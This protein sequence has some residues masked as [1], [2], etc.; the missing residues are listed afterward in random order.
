MHVLCIPYAVDDLERQR[1]SVDESFL[2]SMS[3]VFTKTPNTG[4]A[5]G[6]AHTTQPVAVLGSFDKDTDFLS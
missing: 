3:E 5:R 2:L 1:W 4:I 6:C